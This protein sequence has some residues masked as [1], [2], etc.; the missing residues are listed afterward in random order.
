MPVVSFTN[1]HLNKNKNMSNT[2]ERP[3]IEWL[4]TIADPIVRESAIR[5]C[6]STGTAISLEQNT[7]HKDNVTATC[8]ISRGYAFDT[9][10]FSV[11]QFGLPFV[12]GNIYDPLEDFK[13]NQPKHK[14]IPF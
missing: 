2:T 6:I 4:R 1:F 7:V 14:E 8:K 11:N 5:Q 13:T 9:F 12:V 10:S 3:V